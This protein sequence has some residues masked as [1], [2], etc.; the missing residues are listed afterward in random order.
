[1]FVDEAVQEFSLDE[2][3][4]SVN[5]VSAME[6]SNEEKA[7]TELMDVSGGEET[8]FVPVEIMHEVDS[9]D[10]GDIIQGKTLHWLLER[11]R[12]YMLTMNS[13]LRRRFMQSM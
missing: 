7:S 9:T 1:M 8:N 10:P 12:I 11:K 4:D 13:P 3:E 2:A 5:D 6:D